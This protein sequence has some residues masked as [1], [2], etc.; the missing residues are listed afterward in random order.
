MSL[1]RGDP[2]GKA[3]FGN[4]LSCDGWP[5]V[6]KLQRLGKSLAIGGK[7][8]MEVALDHRTHFRKK[9]DDRRNALGLL[10]ANLFSAFQIDYDQRH[11][12][13]DIIR[14]RFPQ[15]VPG[16]E[17]GGMGWETSENGQPAQQ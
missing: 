3:R 16:D 4:G 13:G 5:L 12:R 7:G 15:V 2:H 14:D 9:L 11:W 10:Q 17:R 6:G 8:Q 1:L